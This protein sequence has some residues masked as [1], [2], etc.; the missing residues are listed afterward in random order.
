[1]LDFFGKLGL[2]ALQQTHTNWLPSITALLRVSDR[3]AILSHRQLA[4]ISGDELRRIEVQLPYQGRT[5]GLTTRADWLPTQFQASF[6]NLLRREA[7]CEPSVLAD[8]AQT[9]T[10]RQGLVNISSKK[11]ST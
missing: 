3:L 11:Q 7:E 5:V 4:E 2:D 6:T 10:E 8:P 1:M 9:M